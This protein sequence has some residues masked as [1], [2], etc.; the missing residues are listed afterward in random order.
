MEESN[1]VKL[2]TNRPRETSQYK[3]SSVTRLGDF[4]KFL[5]T[6]LLTKVSPKDWRLLG[7][8]EID[9]FM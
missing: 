9:Q 1:Q 2:E 5:S 3:A 6:N 8:F 4:L 7:C